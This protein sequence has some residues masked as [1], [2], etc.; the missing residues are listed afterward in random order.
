MLRHSLFSNRGMFLLPSTTHRLFSASTYKLTQ[1]DDKQIFNQKELKVIID[2]KD[3][4]DIKMLLK[5]QRDELER[6]RRHHEK[7]SS[8]IKFDVNIIC[9]MSIM[10]TLLLGVHNLHNSLKT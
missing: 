5:E 8:N 4:S 6:F 2:N 3:I 9:W 10:S 7:Y 1:Y